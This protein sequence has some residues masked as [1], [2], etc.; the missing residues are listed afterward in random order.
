LQTEVFAMEGGEV[1]VR[2]ADAN[3]VCDRAVAV[4]EIRPGE[5]KPREVLIV[6]GAAHCT[7][8]R[9][10]STG[11]ARSRAYEIVSDEVRRIAVASL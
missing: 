2:T 7:P 10:Q 6:E 3:A 1:I 8:Y 9:G 11:V 5:R 4:R